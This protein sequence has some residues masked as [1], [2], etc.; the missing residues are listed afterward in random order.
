VMLPL[1]KRGI[2]GD[3]P[4]NQTVD[5]RVSNLQAGWWTRVYQAPE[6][7]TE[8]DPYVLPGHLRRQVTSRE[9]DNRWER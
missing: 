4:L 8:A 6:F 2:Q 5:P 7:R 1:W 3:F 9:V